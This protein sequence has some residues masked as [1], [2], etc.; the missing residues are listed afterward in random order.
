MSTHF[1][2]GMI[3]GVQLGAFIAMSAVA[4]VVHAKRRKGH[5]WTR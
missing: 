2:L 5:R 3:V 4:W 1:M